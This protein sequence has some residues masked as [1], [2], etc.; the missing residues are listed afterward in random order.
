MQSRSGSGGGSEETLQWR[1][2]GEGPR[3]SPKPPTPES[4]ALRTAP[5]TMARAWGWGLRWEG[6][7]RLCS[8][9]PSLLQTPQ[10]EGNP[11]P[12]TPPKRE[13]ERVWGRGTPLPCLA[14]RSTHWLRI[15]H[16]FFSLPRET[17]AIPEPAG[18]RGMSGIH[19]G[20]WRSRRG[21]ERGAAVCSEPSETAADLGQFLLPQLPSVP[22]LRLKVGGLQ[23][24]PGTPGCWERFGR[25]LL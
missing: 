19:P 16:P 13:R 4:Q 22:V 23:V 15:P 12:S 17:N 3:V 18:P 5:G 1:R 10:W 2:S 24:L 8:R 14:P 6:W 9:Q 7:R 25:D 21:S 11:D 20:A